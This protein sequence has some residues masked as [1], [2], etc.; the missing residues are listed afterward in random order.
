MATETYAYF[1]L[2]GTDLNPEEITRKVGI[3]PTQIFLKG[4]R[5]HPKGSRTRD[6]SGWQVKSSLEQETDIEAHVRS[7][8]EKLKTGWQPLIE[9]IENAPKYEAVINCV[10]YYTPEE[11]GSGSGFHLD[12]SILDQIHQL[13]AEIDF[14]LYV[15]PAE[16]SSPT[17]SAKEL[18]INL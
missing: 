1:L 7:V 6:R 10:M 9:I 11:A 3:T 8:L 4:D 12:R 13:K 16:S 14:D 15:L 18:A 17:A 5:I 2:T